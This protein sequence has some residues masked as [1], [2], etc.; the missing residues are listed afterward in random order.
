MGR[1]K[2]K[3]FSH[4]RRVVC[5]VDNLVSNWSRRKIEAVNYTRP[6]QPSSIVWNHTMTFRVILSLKEERKVILSLKEERKCEP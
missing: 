2:D 4:C 1:V 5:L 3:M 6:L